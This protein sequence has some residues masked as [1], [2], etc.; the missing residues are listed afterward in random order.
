MLPIDRARG[1]VLLVRQLCVPIHVNG[2]SGLAEEGEQI[3]VIEGPLTH[4]WEMVETGQIIDTKT[5]LV[6]QHVQ[7]GSL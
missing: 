6:L 5:M 3:E 1:M 2:D 4:A 7:L